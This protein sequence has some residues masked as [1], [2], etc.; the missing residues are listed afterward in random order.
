M[1]ALERGLVAAAG[2][3]IFENEPPLA[4]RLTALPN[5]VLG[6][7]V[8]SASVSV[9]SE[10]LDSVPS[11]LSQWSSKARHRTLSIP[12]ISTTFLHHLKVRAITRVDTPPSI[13]IPPEGR[14]D[15]PHTDS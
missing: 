3:D 7:H 1:T 9:R 11:T 8:G 6:P 13:H 12:S 5:S 15:S 14:N 2:M 4:P 10:R